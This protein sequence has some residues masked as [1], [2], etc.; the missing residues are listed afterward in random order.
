MLRKFLPVLLIILVS[1]SQ[2][3]KIENA[4]STVL[5]PEEELG[6]ISASV[7]SENTLDGSVAE[8]SV[9]TPG[10]SEKFDRAFENAP[11]MIPHGTVGFFPITIK[12]NICLTCHLPALAV[13]TGSVALPET[14]F[15]NLRP[16]IVQKGNLYHL[17]DLNNKVEQSD[18]SGTLVNAYFNCNQ[19][20]VPQ[21]KVSID[22]ENLFT[23]EFRQMLNKNSSNLSDK[24]N[25]GF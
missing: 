25:E 12:Q 11:P 9:V 18:R 2:S 8:Y 16:E 17:Y 19:C 10:K 6:F 7:Y 1:C 20:H 5:I 24:L 13:A 14:H 22:I 23:P 21:A 3:K 15:T 4:E